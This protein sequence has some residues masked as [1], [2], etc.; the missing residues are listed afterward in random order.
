MAGH[1]VELLPYRVPGLVDG[2]AQGH[3]E[4]ANVV[5][6]SACI[7]WS[8]SQTAFL[9]WWMVAHRVT[10]SLPL[11]WVVLKASGEHLVELFPHRVPGLVDGGAQGHPPRRQAGEVLHDVERRKGVQPCTGW[12]LWMCL[13]QA[14]GSMGAKTRRCSTLPRMR[15]AR[16][17][18]RPWAR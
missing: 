14:A 6:R 11:Q 13:L 3:L 15:L 4:S 7:C 8:F 12:Q 1:L 5:G 18:R 2:G 10:Q 9:G 17:A 16:A